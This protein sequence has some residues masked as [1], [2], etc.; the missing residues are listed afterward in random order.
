MLAMSKGVEVSDRQHASQRHHKYNTTVTWT[1][2]RGQGT[3]SYRGY[4]RAYAT[5]ASG[6]PTLQGS[7][8][9]TF[10]GDS[11]RWNPE[12]LLV[13]SASQCHKLWFLHLASTRRLVVT[14]YQD[15]A[16][17]V[18]LEDQSGAGRFIEIVLHP[19]V[20]LSERS[21]IDEAQACTQTPLHT[22]SS[23]TASTLRL[24]TCLPPVHR[25]SE[26]ANSF[27]LKAADFRSVSLTLDLGGRAFLSHPSVEIVHALRTRVKPVNAALR[28][29]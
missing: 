24:S 4:D 25:A 28:I 27:Q 2:D 9:P 17:A 14:H 18:M 8:D 23:Q 11:S 15:N 5:T 1:G 12:L 7:S 29:P 19:E 26:L 6:R 10:N 13:A 16:E 21:M 20:I 3:K 22:V